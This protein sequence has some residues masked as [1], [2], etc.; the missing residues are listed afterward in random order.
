MTTW[1]VCDDPLVYYTNG[2]L[3]NAEQATRAFAEACDRTRFRSRFDDGGGP[4]PYQAV[5]LLNAVK[6]TIVFFRSIGV[7]GDV[8]KGDAFFYEKVYT[9]LTAAQN[10]LQ[11]Q[12][13]YTYNAIV[14]E[15]FDIAEAVMREEDAV[16]GPA[17]S[18]ASQRASESPLTVIN[19]K[20]GFVPVVGPSEQFDRMTR[21]KSAPPEQPST[22]LA[23]F[24]QAGL[25]ANSTGA[26]GDNH[27]EYSRAGAYTHQ[28]E[29]PEFGLVPNPEQ[30]RS[31]FRRLVAMSRLGQ[32][33]RAA[34]VYAV[35]SA[36]VYL[37]RAVGS[38]GI[39]AMLLNHVDAFVPVIVRGGLGTAAATRGVA[40]AISKLVRQTL[41]PLTQYMELETQLQQMPVRTSSFMGLF[42]HCLG[43]WRQTETQQQQD[44]A[45]GSTRFAVVRSARKF[46][47]TWNNRWATQLGRTF[48][49][50]FGVVNAG[51]VLVLGGGQVSEGGIALVASILALALVDYHGVHVP[52]TRKAFLSRHSATDDSDWIKSLEDQLRIL[53]EYYEDY[54]RY[55][56]RTS[57]YKEI[58]KELDRLQN[59][60][61]DAYQRRKGTRDHRST[62]DKA[63]KQME[64]TNKFIQE[65]REI[66]EKIVDLPYQ[67]NQQQT[68]PQRMDAQS[69]LDL[70]NVWDVDH[71]GDARAYNHY[72][73]FQVWLFNE[74]L[75]PL[76]HRRMLFLPQGARTRVNH[77]D[78]DDDDDDGGGDE[79]GEEEE[80]EEE[81]DDDDD[82]DDDDDVGEGG[83]G[84]PALDGGESESESDSGAGV[85]RGSARASGRW[86]PD[87][88][89]GSRNMLEQLR[90]EKKRRASLVVDASV[91]EYAF[92]RL[93]L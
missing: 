78:D 50:F 93:G 42:S 86:R 68:L 37:Y 38:P 29:L 73:N 21:S 55:F 77:D 35:A 45:L 26:N 6:A 27:D 39:L 1:K 82:D 11:M 89:A 75:N 15:A 7:Y 47:G 34:T 80:E 31:Q 65:M 51:A 49:D 71:G 90:A 56:R 60:V 13:S 16:S 83:E 61:Q 85:G 40:T 32:G 88:L 76:L 58:D 59:L 14:N 63:D 54:Y 8:I 72:N 24:A 2:P 67:W 70:K 9:N 74:K 64:A 18:R 4:E 52:G 66:Q 46:L 3:P 10:Y 43:L 53:R 36:L 41:R 20:R 33:I 79:G 23:V 62:K 84:N 87:A 57:Y 81:N 91:V 25:L 28:Q 17:A 92:A 5:K 44:V 69:L 22:T 12:D 19:A 48:L 30:L